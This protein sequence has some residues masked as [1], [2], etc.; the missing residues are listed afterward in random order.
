MFRSSQTGPGLSSVMGP[1]RGLLRDASGPN[2]KAPALLKTRARAL[3]SSRGR[4][5]GADGQTLGHIRVR[6]ADRMTQPGFPWLSGV[7]W[8]L[9]RTMLAPCN[10]C[11]RSPLADYLDRNADRCG[12]AGADG[13]VVRKGHHAAVQMGAIV[14]REMAAQSAERR[15]MWHAP[16]KNDWQGALEK[17]SPAMI[18][19]GAECEDDVPGCCTMTIQSTVAVFSLMEL[20]EQRF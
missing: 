13:P 15:L 11:H 3:A 10:I 7:A 18:H 2:K 12:V 14:C 20:T 16:S 6:V 19:H 5:M 4:R 8:P 1:I 17:A 9:F